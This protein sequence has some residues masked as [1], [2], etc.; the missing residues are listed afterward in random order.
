MV[1]CISV[2]PSSHPR[3]GGGCEQSHYGRV[4]L[5]HTTQSS[6]A[7]GKKSFTAQVH[8]MPQNTNTCEM[9]GSVIRIASS[10]AGIKRLGQYP[11]HKAE[12]RD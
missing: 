8:A 4:L 3:R 12:Y 5:V 10:V 11:M 6:M 7:R 1:P 9:D 2:L